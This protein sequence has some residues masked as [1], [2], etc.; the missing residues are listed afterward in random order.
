MNFE[1]FWK[2][3]EH[4]GRVAYF[5]KNE[6][7]ALWSTFCPKDQEAIYA[8]IKDKL[9]AGKFVHFVP[10]NAIRD[11]KPRAPVWKILSY[12]EYVRTYHTDLEK[13]GWTKK[14]LPDEHRTIFIKQLN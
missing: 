8:A 3:V 6:A 9:R 12:D 13:D 10:T 7:E 2:L 11:N 5:Y 4:H 14:F 1:D